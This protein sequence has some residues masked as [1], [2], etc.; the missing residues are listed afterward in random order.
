MLEKLLAAI[1]RLTAALET[2]AANPPAA[3]A[4][5][6]GKKAAEKQA[7]PAAAAQPSNTVTPAIPAA[8]PTPASSV[9]TA[10]QATGAALNPE[11]VGATMVQVAN[12]VH[13]DVA[14]AVLGKYGASGF[15]GVKP[16]DYAAF[17]AD[18]TKI[19]ALV[20]QYGDVKTRTAEQGAALVTASLA[21]V[22][23]G[24]PANAAAGL[25]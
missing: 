14:I 22:G 15:G 2:V 24:A 11:T 12:L 23:L 9:A 4:A 13:R 1:E 3:K 19:L 17:L 10:G 7:D 25:M 16:S 8:T 21:A 18:T 5:T 20:P 6:G